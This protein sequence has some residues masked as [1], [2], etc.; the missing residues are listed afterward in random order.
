MR[1]RCWFCRLAVEFNAMSIR[2][3]IPHLGKGIQHAIHFLLVEIQ[4]R[5]MNIYIYNV[6]MLLLI[7]IITP[8]HF[9][10]YHKMRLTCMWS[11]WNDQPVS[12]LWPI[13]LESILI[14]HEHLLFAMSKIC[15]DLFCAAIPIYDFFSF[16]TEVIPVIISKIFHRAI[17]LELIEIA[18]D[19]AKC[20]YVCHRYKYIYNNS[21]ES[22][23][24]NPSSTA[25]NIS[26][27]S[28]IIFYAVATE[29]FLPVFFFLMFYK[30]IAFCGFLISWLA[31][32][33]LLSFQKP[34]ESLCSQWTK[35]DFPPFFN[36]Q[37]CINLRI[38]FIETC[39]VKNTT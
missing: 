30:Y 28:R 24:V 18:R 11:S 25:S 17:F 33:L 36:A 13:P 2:W 10:V 8:I 37:N 7:T 5:H 4:F 12:L 27:R 22:I 34:N 38:N 3:F 32:L 16:C 14:Y 23:S 26:S 1:R 20:V 6:F 29:V 35:C 31:L 21:V 9:G 15:K 19:I 39:D